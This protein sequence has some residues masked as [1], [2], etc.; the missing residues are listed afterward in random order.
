MGL[1]THISKWWDVA[2]ARRQRLIFQ[3]HLGKKISAEQERELEM[4][5]KVAEA[6]VE[7]YSPRMSNGIER[8]A[9]LAVAVANLHRSA[10]K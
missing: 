10:A 7:F 2:N 6:I 3:K 5:Q 4:L 8:A 9:I 1:K